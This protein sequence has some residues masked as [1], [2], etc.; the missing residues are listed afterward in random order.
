[1]D[2]EVDPQVMHVINEDLLNRGRQNIYEVLARLGVRDAKAKLFDYVWEVPGGAPIFTVWAEFVYFHPGAGRM[3]YVESLEETTLLMGGGAM[4]QGQLGRTRERRRLLTKVKGGDPFIVVLQTNERSIPELLRNVTAKPRLRIK[5]SNW[6]IARWDGPRG[7]AIL[8]RGEK[9]WSPTDDEVDEYAAQRSFTSAVTGLKPESPVQLAADVEADLGPSLWFPDQA[10]RERV[11][12]AAVI[13]M[14]SHY[15]ALGLSAESVEDRKLGYDLDVK[16]GAGVS[17]H[18]VEVKGTAGADTAFFLTRRERAC[19]ES[20]PR[21]LLAVVSDALG[22]PRHSV[23][24]ALEMEAAFA[25][26]PLVWRCQA[27]VVPISSTVRQQLRQFS[28]KETR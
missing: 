17:V 23:Y 20:E 15:R 11:E 2:S 18:R 4:D 1:M 26:D 16:D 21:W 12:S 27:G 5:D 24:S 22:S 3:F 7:R 28:R 6:H 13:H 14:Q 9:G 8:V 10:H 25:F 19:S